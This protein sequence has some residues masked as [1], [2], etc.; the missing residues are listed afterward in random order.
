MP[1]LTLP[2]QDVVKTRHILQ[3]AAKYLGK[4]PGRENTYSTDMLP[5]VAQSP[6]KK[7]FSIIWSGALQINIFAC[8]HGLFQFIFFL[9]WTKW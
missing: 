5:K 7:S 1:T 9:V 8:E 4:S 3:T 2:Q 6:N